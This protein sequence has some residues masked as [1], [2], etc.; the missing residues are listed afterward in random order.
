MFKNNIEEQKK[1][2]FW[3]YST[4]KEDYVSQSGVHFRCQIP[5]EIDHP[6]YWSNVPFHNISNTD[7]K[8]DNEAFGAFGCSFT[9]GHGL[10]ENETWPHLLSNKFNKKFLNFGTPGIGIDGIFYNIKASIKDYTFKKIIILLPHFNRRL[11]TLKHKDIWFRWPTLTNSPTSWSKLLPAP[12]HENL[13]IKNEMFKIKGENN[14][15]K[16]FS[17][18]NSIYSKKVLNRMMQFCKQHFNKIYLSTWSEEVY[19]YILELYPENVL[20][21]YKMSQKYPLVRDNHPGLE[22]NRQFVESIVQYIND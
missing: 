15:K 6:F 18:T 12:T 8:K 22:H 7:C 17:D 1:F 4:K 2:F 16:I 21:M 10:Q 9:Y 3:Y 19:Q 5:C 14:V 20:P 11:A 13:Q